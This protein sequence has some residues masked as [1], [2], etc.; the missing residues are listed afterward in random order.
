M[1]LEK[2]LSVAHGSEDLHGK[3]GFCVGTG[4]CGTHFMAKVAGLEPRVGASHERSRLLEA[5]HKYCRWYKLPVD[6]EGFL[7]DKE[8]EIRSDLAGNEFSFEASSY[9]SF[10]IKEL[11]ERFRAKF[12]L[13]V[14]SPSHVVV[15]YSAKGLYPIP[16]IQGDPALAL[17][18]QH[19]PSF[20]HF[21]SRIAP[22]DEE[23]TSWNKMTQV[24]KL[25]WMW[26]AVNS[27]VLEQFETIPDTHWRVQ[28]LEELNHGR[29]LELAAF[30]GYDPAV[31]ASE[32][33][34]LSLRKPGAKAKE[35]RSYQDWS[36][37]EIHEF[38]QQVAPV[39]EY[40]DYEYR[41]DS[42]PAFKQHVPTS[43]KAKTWLVEGLRRPVRS[44]AR[45]LD[46][47]DLNSHRSNGEN[48]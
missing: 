10:S 6:S 16:Y 27:A 1:E 28:K 42:L 29:Y 41:I 43:S 33:E 20:H 13:I 9:L 24:G 26:S 2:E 7:H 38:E 18:Y 48:R 34:A 3:V 15:S 32:Y 5:F 11:Y 4:R 36:A 37:E 21:L 39:A 14:R 12:I 19:H 30:L 45:K 8:R 47:K 35:Y 31:S 23:F 40:F 46:L 25:A 17:G 44:M 22:C